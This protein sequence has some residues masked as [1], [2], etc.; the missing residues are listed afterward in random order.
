[1]YF[2]I[3]CLVGK[4]QKWLRTSVKLNVLTLVTVIEKTNL[5]FGQVSL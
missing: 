1:M 3:I 4:Y 5:R 2:Q